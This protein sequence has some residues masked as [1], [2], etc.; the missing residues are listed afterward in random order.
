M[1]I[2]PRQFDQW[3]Q[4]AIR[5][6]P[7]RFAEALDNIA[8]DVEAYPTVEV[9]R[10]VGLGRGQMLLGLY[11]GVPL[12]ERTHQYGLYGTVPDKIILYKRYIELAA[13]TPEEVRREVAMTLLHEIGHYFGMTEAQLRDVELLDA[14]EA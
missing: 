10:R 13:G 11:T 4:D 8:I 7:K 3:V 14:S 6:L 12:T 9:R 5:M 2:D 1:Q